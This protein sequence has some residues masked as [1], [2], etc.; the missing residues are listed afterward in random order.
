MQAITLGKPP[1]GAEGRLGVRVC[2]HG[3]ATAHGEHQFEAR[4]A[5]DLRGRAPIEDTGHRSNSSSRSIQPTIW[6]SPSPDFKLL[7]TTGREPRTAA[8][9]RAITSRLAPT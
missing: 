4:V 5:A 3:A 2:Q 9:S 8:A 7:N 6:S 1:A